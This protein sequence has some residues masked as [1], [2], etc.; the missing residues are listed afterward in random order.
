[1]PHL[2]SVPLASGRRASVPTAVRAE[3][4]AVDAHLHRSGLWNLKRRRILNCRRFVFVSAPSP[5]SAHEVA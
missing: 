5:R 2:A 1:M 3:A 4:G